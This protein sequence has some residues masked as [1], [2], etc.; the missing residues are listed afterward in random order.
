M[1]TSADMERRLEQ[2]LQGERAQ[3]LATLRNEVAQLRAALR[4]EVGQELQKLRLN[5]QAP[6]KVAG[7]W[8]NF[9][10]G[11]EPELA[12]PVQP[13]EVVDLDVTFRPNYYGEIVTSGGKDYLRQWGGALCTGH[14]LVE[15]EVTGSFPVDEVDLTTFDSRQPTVFPPIW[16]G[17]NLGPGEF[18]DYE[19]PGSGTLYSYVKLRTNPNGSQNGAFLEFH[20]SPQTTVLPD[21][22]SGTPG[23]LF[24]PLNE[25]AVS[26]PTV[27]PRFVG[28]VIQW[29]P[30]NVYRLGGGGS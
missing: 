5:Y 18:T 16:D 9:L 1:M 21:E 6:L 30:V 8:P 12:Q 29:F 13:P 15:I 14:M 25:V 24:Y 10:L 2:A 20:T 11:A 26:G 22:G 17:G 19:L 27:E 28:G 4:V 7:Q 3:V 23:E